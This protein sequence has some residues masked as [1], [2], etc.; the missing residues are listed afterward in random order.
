MPRGN[1]IHIYL[2]DRCTVGAGRDLLR[3]RRGAGKVV[4]VEDDG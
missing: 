1:G 2:R 4:D 3:R